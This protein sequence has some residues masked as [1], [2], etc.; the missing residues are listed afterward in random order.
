MGHK[1]KNTSRVAAINKNAGRAEEN[2]RAISKLGKRIRDLRSDSKMQRLALERRVLGELEKI[3]AIVTELADD[4]ELH[5][6]PWYRKAIDWTRTTL[7]LDAGEPEP[8]YLGAIEADLDIANLDP[9]LGTP[10][11]V[12]LDNTD[13]EET[14]PGIT[15]EPDIFDVA[16]AI[17]EESVAAQVDAASEKRATIDEIVGAVEDDQAED[18]QAKKALRDRI[19]NPEKILERL[20]CRLSAERAYAGAASM[21]FQEEERAD[22]LDK[23]SAKIEELK[24]RIADQ[25]LIIAGLPSEAPE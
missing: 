7:R 1:R 25:K 4:F 21:T 10:R 6:R 18:D 19:H 24:S 8:Y 23:S 22:L 9:A 13:D 17:T 12:E 20:E 14:D 2:R 3:A 11:E 5:R 15:A 16:L